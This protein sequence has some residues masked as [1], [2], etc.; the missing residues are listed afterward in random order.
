MSNYSKSKLMTEL[1]LKYL[2]E[3]RGLDFTSIRMA[4]V[5][6]E[7][8]HK[9]QGV[10]RLLFSIVDD[11]MPFLLTKKGVKHS[12]SNANKLPYF[13]HH[14]LKNREEFSGQMYNF[15]DEEPVQL[16]ELILTIKAQ[17]DA[18]SPKAIYIPHP[19]AKLGKTSVNWLFKWL[20]KIGVRAR[21]PAELVFLDNF[22][23]VDKI[24]VPDEL[25]FFAAEVVAG[26]EELTV[27]HKTL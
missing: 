20:G 27:L 12:Y 15:V 24:E 19:V 9:I 1:T 16:D 11:S 7:H 10:Q 5:Y 26:Q 25:Q 17:L 8:D 14:I 21:L 4:V 3:T 18:S 6:G 22:D 23:L 2:H 13:M